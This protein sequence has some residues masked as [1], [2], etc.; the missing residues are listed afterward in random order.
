[1]SSPI[2]H[3]KKYPGLHRYCAQCRKD[4]TGSCTFGSKKK[5]IKDCKY[6]ERHQYKV[7]LYT[8]EGKRRTKLLETRDFDQAVIELLA[9]KREIN[10]ITPQ[11]AAPPP[12]AAP[13]A[14]V[15]PTHDI[16]TSDNLLAGMA[17]YVANLAGD[18]TVVP[19]FRRRSRSNKHLDDVK[20]ALKSLA[21]S[22]QNAGCDVER[23][24]TNDVTEKLMGSFH[25]HLLDEQELSNRTY[26]KYV[27]IISS[28]YTFLSK[29]GHNV[30]NPCAKIPRRAIAKNTQAITL[31][32]FEKLLVVVTK[33]ELG[34]IQ[35][36]KERKSYYRPWL[37]DSFRLAYHTGRRNYELSRMK[38][39]DI[40]E[41]AA[42]TPVYMKHPD[43]KV[44]RQKGIADTDPNAKFISV[45]VTEEL[46]E[47]LFD[48]G[49]S[50][51][52]GTDR[53]LI[54][55]DESNDRDTIKDVM[56]RAFSIYYRHVGNRSLTLRSC[57][58]AYITEL[59]MEIGMEN[60]RHITKHSDTAVIGNNYI[61]DAQMA[62]T[63]AKKF[64]RRVTTRKGESPELER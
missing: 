9:F 3:N 37:S 38:F 18:P 41:D 39:S 46:R 19:A 17:L 23:M 14:Q 61:D 48:L 45:P 56:A 50:E 63:V 6:P 29:E 57:R 32:E 33:P 40:H 55:G 36:G 53:Y 49:Y 11:P 5:P 26:N 1:M 64:R 44:N 2:S 31:E 35:A 12:S 28:F 20:R 30:V 27:G 13:V 51:Y 34:V 15:T 47:V 25:S 7:I 22:L 52:R 16:S 54:A 21:I 4:I 42:G 59:S 58:R 60:A 24:H 43:T 62:T 8:N 10:G